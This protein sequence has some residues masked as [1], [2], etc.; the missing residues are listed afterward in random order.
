M[1]EFTDTIVPSMDSEVRRSF[2]RVLTKQGFAFKLGT[3]CVGSKIVDSGKVELTVEPA[4][5]GPQETLEADVV[6]VSVGACAWRR[7]PPLLSH[8][9]SILSDARSFTL[10]TERALAR[11][12]CICCTAPILKPRDLKPSALNALTSAAST[13][14]RPKTQ[15]LNLEAAGVETDGRGFIKVDAKFQT[16]AEGV[17]AIGDCI[18]GPM[19]AH[20]VRSMFLYLVC[21]A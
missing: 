11:T 13:G 7:P 10:S 8:P 4:K 20:K 9:L 19:L 17:Y 14:R 15:G 6:L 12:A 1:V 21:C 5:G 2:Q 3:K 16:T 18:P